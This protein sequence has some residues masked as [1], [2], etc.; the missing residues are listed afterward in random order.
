MLNNPVTLECSINLHET[1][2]NSIRWTN[3]N[4]NKT[5]KQIVSYEIDALKYYH[6][7]ESFVCEAEYNLSNDVKLL[8]RQKVRKSYLIEIKNIRGTNNNKILVTNLKIFLY[9]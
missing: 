9:K 4:S 8:I 5:H 7:N 2:I 3:D 6:H 1:L